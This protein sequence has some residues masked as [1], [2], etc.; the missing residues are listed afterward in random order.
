MVLF[1]T[2]FTVLGILSGPFE[3]RDA[4]IT[5]TMLY[6]IL[7]A[8]HLLRPSA[9]ERQGISLRSGSAPQGV[10]WELRDWADWFAFR[11]QQN[12]Q[13]SVGFWRQRLA[14]YVWAQGLLMCCSAGMESA[15]LR[16]DNCIFAAYMMFPFTIVTWMLIRPDQR[17]KLQ[18]SGIGAKSEVSPAPMARENGARNDNPSNQPINPPRPTVVPP[19]GPAKPRSRV[20]GLALTPESLRSLNGRQRLADLT[21]SMSWAT[22]LTL[23]FAIGTG[24]LSPLFVLPSSLQPDLAKLGMFTITTLAAAWAL[25]IAGKL[26]EG[27]SAHGRPKRFMNF[28]LGLGVGATSWWLGQILMVDLPLSAAAQHSSMFVSLGRQPLVFDQHPTLLAFMVFF[29]FLFGIRRWWWHVDAFRPA[30]FRITSVI[31]TVAVAAVLPL[32]FSFPWDWAVTW[33]AV[34][35]CVVQLS[36]VWTPPENRT[37]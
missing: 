34:I 21:V 16:S 35:S 2:S 13:T 23:L 33:A 25:I 28:L 32:V 9:L 11:R 37:A 3:F 12:D 26:T 10:H 22:I 18:N 1:A 36:A 20:S 6:T 29:G 19:N 8:L 24:F 7:M 14:F 27:R 4:A 5:C 17:P 15:A 30:L 31:M